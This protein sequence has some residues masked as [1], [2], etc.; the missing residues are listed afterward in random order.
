MPLKFQDGGNFK[1]HIRYKAST[2]SW[3]ISSENGMQT[4]QL[5]P[6]VFDLENIKTGWG[7]FAE[8]TAPEWVWDPSLEQQNAKPADDREWMHG[9]SVNIL[10]PKEYEPER[11]REFAT[12]STGAKEGIKALYAQYEE[13]KGHNPG[14]VP[15]VQYQGATPARIGKG[16]TNIPTLAIV[17]WIDRPAALD[18]NSQQNSQPQNYAAQGGFAQPQ[19]PPAQP[20]QQP[21]ANPVQPPA[22]PQGGNDL[23]ETD[24]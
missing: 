5:Q 8:N 17:K 12:T 22:S 20:A 6:S 10:L 11:L 7:A 1:P 23:M 4:L 21:A 16:N 19:Q 24:F 14:K 18:E 13:Q 2:S 15:V 3:E 9:F